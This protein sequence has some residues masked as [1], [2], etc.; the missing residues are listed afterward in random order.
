MNTPIAALPESFGSLSELIRLCV[1]RA[2]ARVVAALEPEHFGVKR[3]ARD[4]MR[5]CGRR[6]VGRSCRIIIDTPIGALPES[7]TS[8]P[9]LR[10]LCVRRAPAHLGVA[11]A[12]PVYLGSA[13][14]DRTRVC[15][16]VGSAAQ[17]DHEHVDRRTAR[18]VRQP[19]PAQLAVRPPGTLRAWLRHLRVRCS[20]ESAGAVA[21]CGAACDR[22]RGCDVLVRP[23]RKIAKTP[24]AALP[25]SFGRLSQL[26]YLC[27]R[28]T[29]AHWAAALARPVLF[30]V[31]QALAG[32]GAA[33]D[34]MHVCDVVGSTMQGDH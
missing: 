12:R 29:P 6:G 33:R 14:R 22:M 4:R 15:D 19:A 32:C 26:S 17:D 16:V 5:A 23:R 1:R 28:R 31:R 34:R 3:A 7:F 21:G 20:L 9:Q 24:I 8:L 18:V 25:D 27:V 13:A 2:P 10:Y 30:G 11:L